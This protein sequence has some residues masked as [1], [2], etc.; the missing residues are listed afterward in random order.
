MVHPK[1][2]FTPHLDNPKDIATKMEEELSRSYNHHANFKADRR[3][4]HRDVCIPQ[5]IELQQI[6]KSHT[7]VALRL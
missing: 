5:I 6:R 1:P 7:G 4:R 3:H 2:F